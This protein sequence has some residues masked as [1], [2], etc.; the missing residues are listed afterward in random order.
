M[1]FRLGTLVIKE[2]YNKP[3]ESLLGSTT[4]GLGTLNGEVQ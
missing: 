3:V 2:K 1:P 4:F